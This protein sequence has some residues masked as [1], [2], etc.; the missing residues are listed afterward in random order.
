M[1]HVYNHPELTGELVVN[2][3][4]TIDVPLAGVIRAAGTTS[5][6]VA[7]RIRAALAA[8]MKNPAVEVGLR[9]EAAPITVAGWPYPIADGVLKYIPE[10]TLAGAIAAIRSSGAGQTQNFNPFHSRINMRAVRIRRDGKLLGSY[11]MVALSAAGAA[12]PELHPGDAVEFVNKPVAVYVTGEV[13]QPGLAYLAADE[14]L[15][16]SLDQVAGMTDNA[17]SAGLVLSRD[18]V[19]R[20]ISVADSAFHEPARNDDSLFVPAAPQITV[21]GA[22]LRSGPAQLKGDRSLLAAVFVAGGPDK[23]G[24]LGQVRLIRNGGVSKYDITRLMRGDFTQNPALQDGDQI[25]VPRSAHRVD[26][27]VF[28]QTLYALRLLILRL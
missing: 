13:K 16:D 22:V 6:G 26:P 23:D 12:G 27:N 2:S 20:T 5:T 24:D 11:D 1:V 3:D 7:A 9:A 15:S 4:G 21:A 17:A 25:Y 19:A 14:P 28:A 10:Q 8:Y 18:G